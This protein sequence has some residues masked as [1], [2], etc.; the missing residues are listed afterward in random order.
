[1]GILGVGWAKLVENSSISAPASGED[2]D[3]DLYVVYGS[4]TAL[5]DIT[6]DAYYI[7][8]RVA[9][10]G[11]SAVD[12]LNTIGVRVAADYMGFD[13]EAE[14][15]GQTGDAEVTGTLG[16]EDFGGL[17]YNVEVGYTFDMD[18]QPRVYVGFASFE[19]TETG[20]NGDFGFQRIFSDWEYGEFL[21]G[22]DLANVSIFRFGGS[23][24]LTES[25]DVALAW[26]LYTVDE[27]IAGADDDLGSEVALYL[28]Y[29]YSEDL[30]IG[31]GYAP[32]FAEDGSGEGNFV[33]GNGSVALG[34]GPVGTAPDDDADYFF[35]ETSIS[36]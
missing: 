10:V 24:Q 36:F 18:Y 4:Y 31:V 3:T 8:V 28:N 29:A 25:I 21:D 17:G 1:M 26:A 5:E 19:G 35:F 11:S 13:I 6:I 12:D 22:G 30:S 33:L 15:A 34:A 16:T 9:A 14:V 20:A 23:A 7:L 32:Y 2:D 27:E